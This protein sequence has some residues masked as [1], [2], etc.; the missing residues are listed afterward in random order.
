MLLPTPRKPLQPNPQ[1]SGRPLAARGGGKRAKD[2]G[3][4]PTHLTAP[5]EGSKSAVAQKKTQNKG[6]KRKKEFFRPFRCPTSSETGW[7]K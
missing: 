6:E 4:K 1:G 7:A 3:L 2:F 5:G